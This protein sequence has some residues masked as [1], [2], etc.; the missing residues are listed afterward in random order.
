M[1]VQKIRAS[2]ADM[3]ICY[4][5]IKAAYERNGILNRIVDFNIL[6]ESLKNLKQ[7]D[8]KVNTI[9]AKISD[10]QK[11]R[12]DILLLSKVDSQYNLLLSTSIRDLSQD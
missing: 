3:K 8:T 12:D 4:S 7:A 6:S 2:F 9:V 11:L 10:L 5:D 1:Q